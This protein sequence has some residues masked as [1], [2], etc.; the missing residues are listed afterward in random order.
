MA[1]PG[2]NPTRMELPKGAV[3]SPPD[4]PLKLLLVQFWRDIFGKEVQ[5]A[6]TYSYLWI[7]DQMGHV[8]VGIVCQFAM[9]FALGH[10]LAPLLDIGWLATWAN[11]L[12]LAAVAGA[13]SFWEWRA[14]TVAKAGA[15]SGLFP[16][17]EDI[18]RRNAIIATA[19]MIFG[20][21]VGYGFQLSAYWGALVFLVMVGAAMVCAPPWLRQKITWQK[22]SLPYLFR[23]ADL[24]VDIPKPLAGEV[25]RFIDTPP[26]TGAPRQMIIV[27]PVA[28]G[29][30]PM[31]CGLGTELAFK[32][33]KVRYLSFDTLIEISDQYR[34]RPP[35]AALPPI[36]P[37]GPKNIFYWPWFEAE[38][39][40]ID[41][42]SPIIGT[43]MREFGPD[44]FEKIL[45]TGLAGAAAELRSRD[46]IW[47]FGVESADI[48]FKLARP[49]EEIAL[50]YARDIQAFC[51]AESPPLA[52][53]LPP[54]E[55]R[56]E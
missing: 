22:A 16:L 10:V 45:T 8:A 4:I 28:S 18:L 32:K 41:D 6:A 19:Y 1:E 56:M 31:V 43:A 35:D 12:A 17:D 52:V 9:A 5:S 30:T 46:T 15:S 55:T 26:A 40:I 7:A 44:T 11:G 38:T 33:R 48:S 51:Q 23:L 29:R 34:T 50:R 21:V 54:A 47:V 13:V 53:R 3:P 24:S 20:V 37:W 14:F 39:L 25:Q 2:N 49:G 42:I 36:G 27:G